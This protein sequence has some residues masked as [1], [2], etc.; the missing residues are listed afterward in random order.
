[1]KPAKEQQIE[2]IKNASK[3]WPELIARKQIDKISGGLINKRTIANL[4]ALSKGPSGVVRVG[5]AVAYSRESLV[6]WLIS[7]LK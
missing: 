7:K 1:M 5:N 3:T 2:I 6:S 4:D